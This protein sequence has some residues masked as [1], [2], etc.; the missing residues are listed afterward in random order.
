MPLNQGRLTRLTNEGFPVGD[1]RHTIAA[2]CTCP[3][4]ASSEQ[5]EPPK[6]RCCQKRRSEA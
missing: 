2:A 6:K 3:K 5:M 1:G 4:S